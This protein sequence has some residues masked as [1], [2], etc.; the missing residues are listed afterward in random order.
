MFSYL[1]F[2]GGI[3]G[4]GEKR[5][6]TSCGPQESDDGQREGRGINISYF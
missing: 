2:Q 1:S 4:T 3:Q 5:V 6:T